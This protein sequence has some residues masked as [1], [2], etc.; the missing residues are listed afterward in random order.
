MD[1][2]YSH[3]DTECFCID[4][5][6]NS[7][8]AENEMCEKCYDDNNLRYFCYNCNNYYNYLDINNICHIYIQSANKI[9]KQFVIFTNGITQ[10][11]RN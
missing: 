8:N 2:I 6:N 1:S 7:L 9:K 3:D 5:G 10:I 11:K 4:C